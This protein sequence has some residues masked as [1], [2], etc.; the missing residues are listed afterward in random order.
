MKHGDQTEITINSE[1]ESS[2]P[3]E[4]NAAT[5]VGQIWSDSQNALACAQ[6][7]EGWVRNKVRHVCAAWFWFK[8]YVQKRELIVR[9]CRGADQVGQ[10][11]PT[12]GTLVVAV[13]THQPHGPAGTTVA[14][15]HSPGLLP[16]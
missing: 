15:G 7:P 2:N 8:Q 3:N 14:T 10:T 9:Y 6:E 13:C 11:S 5:Y 16:A 12:P 4:S 1:K